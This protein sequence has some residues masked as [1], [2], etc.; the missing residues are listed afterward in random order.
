[1]FRPRMS[2]FSTWLF[3]V[4]HW[5]ESF[6]WAGRKATVE[7]TLSWYFMGLEPRDAAQRIL[8]S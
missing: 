7:E 3:K 8:A 4:N 1:M 2:E 6:G 5:L